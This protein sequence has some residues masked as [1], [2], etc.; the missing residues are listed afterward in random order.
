MVGGKYQL[1]R[2]LGSGASGAVYEGRDGVTRDRVAVK[3]LHGE[4]LLSDEHVARFLKEARTAATIKHPG[5]VAFLDAGRHDDGRPYLVQEFLHGENLQEVMDRSEVTLPMIFDVSTQ[6]LE[7]LD[8]VHSQGLVHRDIKPENV[9]MFFGQYG[10]V[11]IKLVDFGIV[12]SESNSRES[13]G[14]ITETGLTVGTPHYMSPEQALG[15]DVDARSDIWSVG[16]MLFEMLTGTLPIDG[17]SPYIVLARVVSS[18]PPSIRTRREDLPEWLVG[19]VDG[20]LQRDARSRW[21]TAKEM[22][23]ALATGL[24]A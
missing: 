7:A 15:H 2:L 20:A 1:V 14:D 17:E 18:K 24:K 13:D 23:D 11:K 12:K 22:N 21:Q 3:L 4:L 16:V 19:V 6:L 8:V 5:I 9:L 10:D